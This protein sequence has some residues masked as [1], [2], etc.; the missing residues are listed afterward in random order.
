MKKREK[1]NIIHKWY[2]KAMTTIDNVNK[3]I[4]FVEYDLDLEPRQVMLA[5]SI[6]SDDVNSIQYPARTQE[7]L[8][9]FKMGGL[10]GFPFTGLTGMGAFASHVP[11]D[12]AVF[13]YYGPH[14]GIT[15]D[16]TI[17]EIHR[18]GQS[19]NSGCCGAA[20]G[21]LGKL[22][23]DQI[24]AGNITELDYQ[25]NTIEQILFNKKERVLQA[26]TPLFEATEVIYEA[27]DQR[28]NELVD[29]T[30]YSCKYVILVGAILINSDSDMG[31]FTE[32]RR[33][34]VIDLS[35]KTRQ[36]K[37]DYLTS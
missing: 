14:I 31:S 30:N 24:I 26:E 37:I 12:G 15:K 34:D 23:N 19:K 29:K 3:I 21:A 16:G 7:F 11:D 1:L 9:P 17:G 36:S 8:G 20:K 2:P 4:D 22:I 10:D 18:L 28:I 6:C 5:D 35:T 27:I 33:F 13:I 25:M 32:V